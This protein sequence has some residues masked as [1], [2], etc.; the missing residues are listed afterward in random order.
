MEPTMRVS[1]LR[2]ITFALALTAVFA[3]NSG[4]FAMPSQTAAQQ[5]GSDSTMPP[6][7]W[8]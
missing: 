1:L 8:E 2:T 7:L 4:A 3:A 6:T 5:Q